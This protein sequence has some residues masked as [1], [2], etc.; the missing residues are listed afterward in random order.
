MVSLS[1]GQT[2][3]S[4]NP[5]GVTKILK[6]S[7]AEMDND[8]TLFTKSIIDSTV[9]VLVKSNQDT[10]NVEV[11]EFSSHI[12]EQILNLRAKINGKGTEVRYSPQMLRLAM[13]VWSRSK[14]SYANLAESN[15]LMIPCSRTL[16][17]G[18]RRERSTRA[19]TL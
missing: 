5:L 2:H 17:S 19:I 7:F 4:P 3:E 12:S 11:E 10:D 9:R 18:E 16:H 15:L 6:R 1:S 13:A 8:K 14:T